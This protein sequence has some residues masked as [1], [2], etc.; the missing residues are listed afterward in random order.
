MSLIEVKNISY[1]YP[2]GSKALQ[3]IDLQVEKGEFVGLLASNGSG[4]TTLLRC[5]NGLIKSQLGDVTIDGEPISRLPQK[6]LFQRIGMVFQ[7]P[8]DQLFASTV[9]ED[10]AFGPSNMGLPTNEIKN[11]IKMELLIASFIFLY[12]SLMLCL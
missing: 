4:K 7:N 1:T 12:G 11:R 10:V 2:D 5:I 3:G 9:A 6:I 8:N